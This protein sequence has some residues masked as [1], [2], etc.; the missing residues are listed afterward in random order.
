MDY[1]QGFWPKTRSFFGVFLP[2]AERCYETEICA[3]L[4]PFRCPFAGY[5]FLPEPNFS[6]LGRKPWT[7]V[8]GFGRN[9]VNFLLSFYSSLEGGMKLKF[10]PFCS[11]SDVLLHGI[12]FCQI[13]DVQFLAKTI[14]HSDVL[15]QVKVFNFWP[16]TH[17][18]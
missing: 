9:Q 5:H 4:P 1:S 2:L 11:P 13:K 18:L 14:C 16:K 7:A 3:T 15:L 17:G 8:R 12:I 6:F 10:V